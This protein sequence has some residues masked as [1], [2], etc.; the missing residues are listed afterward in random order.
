MSTAT[1][2]ATAASSAGR[3]GDRAPAESLVELMHRRLDDAADRRAIIDTLAEAVTPAEAGP[4][5]TRATAWTWGE[6]IAAAATLADAFAAA[7]LAPGDRVAHVGPHAPDW[8]LVDFACLLAGVVHVPL[9]A[10]AARS[11]QLDQLAWLEPRGVVFS[12]AA[13]PGGISARDVRGRIVIEVGAGGPQAAAGLAGSE[14]RG[15]AAAPAALVDRVALAVERCDPDAAATIVLSSGTT[16]RP[17]G[18]LHS[19]RSLAANA[20]AAADVFLDDPRDVRLSWLPMSHAMAR[21]GDLGT[22]LVR[23]GCLSVVRHRTRVLDACRI[24]PPTAILGVPA[25]YER[26]ERAAA[27]GRIVDLA[28]ALGGDIRVCVS[29]GAPLRRRTAEFFAAR[30]VPLV[31]GYGLAEAGPVI[32]LSNPRMARSGTV[33]LPLAGIQVRLD[34]RPATRGQLLVSTPSRALGILMPPVSPGG[35]AQVSP[36]DSGDGWLE[37]GDLAEIDDAGHV[38]ITGRLRDTLVL[39]NGVKLPPAAVEAALAEDDAVAQVC[40]VGAGLPRPVAIIV[41]EP[42]V[43]RGA[44]HRMGLRVFS[45]RQA[46]GHPRVAAWLARRLARRQRA[47]PQAWRVKTFLIADRGFDA[48]HGEATESLK[49]KREAIAAHFRDRVERAAAAARSSEGGAMSEPLPASAGGSWLPAALWQGSAGGFAAAASRAAEPLS[50][51]AEA[52]LD[53]AEV[54]IA[55]LRAA[56]QLYDPLATPPA[57]APPIDDPPPPQSGTFSAVAETV[58]GEAGL[59]GLAVPEAFGGSGVSMLDLTRV[60]TRLAANVPTCAGLLA[61]H[62][63]IGAV[64]AVTGFGSVEQQARLLPGLA[65][66]RPLSIFGA[67]ESDAGCDLGR[68][69]ATLERRADGLLLTGT[70]MFI[71]GATHGRLVKLLAM[72][73]G[74]PA[75]VVVRLPEA[76]TPTFRLRRYSLHPLKHAHNAALEF[77]AFDVDPADVLDPGGS[78]DAMRIVWHGLNRGRVTLAAQAAGTLRLLL[79]QATDH[80]A[81]RIT[82]KQ[83]IGS[84][85]LVQGRLGRIAA[86]IVACDALAA[87]GATAIDAGQ[88]GEWEAITAKVVASECVREAAIDALGVHGGRAFLVGHPLGD[89]FHDHF[90][91]TVYEGESDLLGLA[92][93]KGLAKQHPLAALSRE[94]TASRRAAAWL[95]WRVRMLAGTSRQDACILDRRLRDHARQARRQLSAAAIRIDRAV[96]RHGRGLAE[97]QLEIASLAAE[98]RAAVSMLA[99]AHH[100][101]AA[102]DD[103]LLA[104]ADVWCRLALARAAGRRPL[105]DD[106]AALAALGREAIRGQGTGS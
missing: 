94:A 3:V 25:F 101:D 45:R 82:W 10:D 35:P 11:E 93:F 2:A 80:A 1:T 85:Q 75:V 46:V 43:L 86:S 62:S 54:E 52:V 22:A 87:W 61:V 83:P 19:Q 21:T 92:L 56:G 63:S 57:V 50:N 6:L 36:A 47:L 74:R 97:R 53:R 68:V 38:R 20:A 41:P 7:G 66:G 40:L 31:E 67:T 48:A 37:T 49:L 29:G 42:E 78:A 26:L 103:R 4:G 18:V 17:H 88:S 28:A 60:I 96:R 39:S 34:E 55:R 15:L 27:S 23:G 33:G 8:I 12:A 100:A 14:W 81:G 95:R 104:P 51:R 32:A 84:R 90:A 24:L 99:V 79:A 64:S 76:D 73:D 69:R 59:W 102:G 89:S 98:V 9:H 5:D 65:A 44:I 71:T 91:V 58:L 30:G 105:P 106:L 16:G 77:T 13:V 70:K 72:L